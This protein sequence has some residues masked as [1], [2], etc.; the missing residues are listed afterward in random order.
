MAEEN[1]YIQ[2]LKENAQL[3]KLVA[4]EELYEINLL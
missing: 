4:L 1:K 2:S 3:G